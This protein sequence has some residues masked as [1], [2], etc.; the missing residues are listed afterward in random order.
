MFLLRLVLEGALGPCGGGVV[1]ERVDRTVAQEDLRA[2]VPPAPKRPWHAPQFVVA[3]EAT[4]I[5]TLLTSDAG[6]NQNS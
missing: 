1:H 5:V 4:N 3:D 6:Y 2:S